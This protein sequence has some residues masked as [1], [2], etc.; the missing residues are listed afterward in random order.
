VDVERFADDLADGHPV[1][2]A[3]LGVLEDDLCVAPPLRE[4]R[5]G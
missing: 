4:V 1:V 5:A 3:G 2:E